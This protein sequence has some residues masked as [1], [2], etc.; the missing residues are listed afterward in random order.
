MSSTA[1][2]PFPGRKVCSPGSGSPSCATC[3]RDSGEIQRRRWPQRLARGK[4]CLWRCIQGVMRLAL[5]EFQI[6]DLA[7]ALANLNR[8]CRCRE[9]REEAGVVEVPIV[10]VGNRRELPV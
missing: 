4:F 9:L 3:R 7:L 5:Q 1:F 6:L 2:A 10:K 8:R